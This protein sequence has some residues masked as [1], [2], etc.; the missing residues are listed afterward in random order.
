LFGLLAGVL[1]ARFTT[2]QRRDTPV[3]IK[4]A[5]DTPR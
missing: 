3:P 5:W 1:V 2:R 4:G